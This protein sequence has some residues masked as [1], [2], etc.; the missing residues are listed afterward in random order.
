MLKSDTVIVLTKR[1]C[2]VDDTG[3]ILVRDVCIRHNSE[4]PVLELCNGIM[5]MRTS[6]SV[7]DGGIPAP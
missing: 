1:W 4:C 6:Q 7:T 5:S 2:L 3:T